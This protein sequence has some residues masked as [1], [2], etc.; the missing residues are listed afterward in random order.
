MSKTIFKYPINITDYQVLRMP[1]EAEVNH[2]GLDPTGRPCVWAI[3]DENSPARNVG[4]SI[5]GTGHAIPDD[6]IFIG[7]FLKGS[8]VWHVF[9]IPIP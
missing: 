7:T 1:A 9:I 6:G 8:H 4:I 2:V 5:R 3:V